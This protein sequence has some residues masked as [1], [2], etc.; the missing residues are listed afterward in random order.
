MD[1]KTNS[2]PN[3]NQNG[4]KVVDLIPTIAELL[5]EWE[6]TIS[7]KAERKINGHK[8]IA[9][10]MHKPVGLIYDWLNQYGTRT[11]KMGIND[12]AEI[13]ICMM[14]EKLLDEFVAEFR[15]KVSDRIKELHYIN[16]IQV[17]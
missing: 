12:C 8:A 5:D 16:Q 1:N 10:R 2:N 13:L 15:T 7:R 14:D 9:D 4:A 11:A 3:D 17:K 6:Y